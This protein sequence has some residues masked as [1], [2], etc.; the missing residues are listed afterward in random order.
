MGNLRHC[1]S[2]GHE[3]KSARYKFV[4]GGLALQVWKKWYAD[5]EQIA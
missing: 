1:M 2:L 5:L 4:K 3:L